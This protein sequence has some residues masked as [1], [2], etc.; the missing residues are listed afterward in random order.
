MPARDPRRYSRFRLPLPLTVVAYSEDPAEVR[1]R[2]PRQTGRRRRVL[3][4]RDL[5]LEDI[6][7]G[8]ARFRLHGELPHEYSSRAQ[9]VLTV[10]LVESPFHPARVF[11]HCRGHIVRREEGNRIA[12]QFDSVELVRQERWSSLPLPA[13]TS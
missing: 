7:M 4:E 3:L 1:P 6:S 2:T 11:A 5:T 9:F 10:P 13:E 8:G 12:V